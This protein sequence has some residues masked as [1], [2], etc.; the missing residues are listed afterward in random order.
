MKSEGINGKWKVTTK[1]GFA[2]SPT[3][4][5]EMNSVCN[6]LPL[7]RDAILLTFI[8]FLLPINTQNFLEATTTKLLQINNK[9]RYVE[10][11]RRQRDLMSVWC[12]YYTLRGHCKRLRR[13]LY[14]FHLL[15]EQFWCMHIVKCFLHYN[16]VH[17]LTR[18][19][20]GYIFARSLFQKLKFDISTKSYHLDFCTR[21]LLCRHQLCSIVQLSGSKG[22]WDSIV[23]R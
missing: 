19:L 3:W 7:P 4:Q 20:P 8:E 1:F 15:K 18:L 13:I 21:W 17:W 5:K 11:Y 14:W 9:R 22:E 6:I 12:I 16:R 23:I 10:P 2:R